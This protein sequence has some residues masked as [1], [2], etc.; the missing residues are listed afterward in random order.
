MAESMDFD[1]TI[2]M[3]A[4]I[5]QVQSTA[6]AR[7]DPFKSFISGGAG[8]M[9]LVLVGHPLDLIKVRLQTTSQYA[10][11]SDAFRVI[12][13]QD[14][15][16]GLY[17]G[18][19]TP[20][21]GVTPI[22][23]ICFWGYDLG[24]RF[25]KTFYNA[26]DKRHPLENGQKRL[27]DFKYQMRATMFAGGF[28]ALP[29]T[30]LMTPS[31]RIK[32]MLQIQ[33]TA[34]NAALY[35]GPLDIVKAVGIRELYK[36]TLAT[37]ARDVPGSVAYFAAYEASK[38]WMTNTFYRR[39]GNDTKEGTAELP[40]LAILA[41]GGLAGWANWFVAIPADVIKSRLQASTQTNVSGLAI[42]KSL[43]KEEGPKALFKGLG[44][45]L[46]RSF[47]ANAACFLG[48]EVSLSVMNKLW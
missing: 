38:Y 13:K 16:R 19:M 46:V 9:S 20:L 1:T 4:Q 26:K 3:E 2:K 18:M 27:D 41:A 10:S 12:L 14:G 48:V 28:S 8:G 22:F 35:K 30:L 36:G 43:L 7:K 39:T 31:E 34:T 42:L 40:I 29:T 32:V 6:T 37:L 25:A 33:G 45:A 24:Q 44:P 21:V 47:P 15:I 11:M 5:L 17:R 23:A